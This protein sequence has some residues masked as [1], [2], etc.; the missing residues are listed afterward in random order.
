[1]ALAK[2]SVVFQDGKNT[3]SYK[4]TRGLI[5]LQNRGDDRRRASPVS[6]V[7]RSVDNVGRFD[8]SHRLIGSEADSKKGLEAPARQA[9]E[10]I[11]LLYGLL[12]LLRFYGHDIALLKA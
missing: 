5:S 7:L 6:E 9:L 8:K 4:R 1:M 10:L 11:E 2:T 3:T 12:R